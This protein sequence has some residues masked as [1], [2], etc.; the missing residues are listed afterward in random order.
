[1]FG[2]RNCWSDLEFQDRFHAQ[3]GP[4]SAA[5]CGVGLIVDIVPSSRK[6]L[7]LPRLPATLNLLSPAL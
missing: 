1:M 2:A 5:G 7:L 6:L 3:V 4:G